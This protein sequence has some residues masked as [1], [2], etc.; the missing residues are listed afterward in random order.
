MVSLPIK[1]SAIA[2]NNKLNP[3]QH[4]LLRGL[5]LLPQDISLCLL[6]GNKVPQG[7]KPLHTRKSETSHYRWGGVN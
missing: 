6:N 5:E 4:Q 3:L 2:E 1:P 7:K